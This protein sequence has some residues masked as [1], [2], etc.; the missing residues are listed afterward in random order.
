MTDRWRCFTVFNS[1]STLVKIAFWVFF[2]TFFS[3]LYSQIY[4]LGSSYF[5]G[6]SL[7]PLF[8]CNMWKHLFNSKCL[9]QMHCFLQCNHFLLFLTFHCSRRTLFVLI[10]HLFDISLNSWNQLLLLIQSSFL[11]HFLL[12]SS[13]IVKNF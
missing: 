8:P 13:N 4:S 6:S 3:F 1:T 5:P 7:M 9:L 11:I 2:C 12:N 10:F